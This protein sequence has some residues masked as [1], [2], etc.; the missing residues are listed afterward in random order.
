MSSIASKGPTSFL[1]IGCFLKSWP[2]ACLCVSKN[3]AL[4]VSR[5]S[6]YLVV[7]VCIRSFTSLLKKR[8]KKSIGAVPV[9]LAFSPGVPVKGRPVNKNNMFFLLLLETCIIPACVE[10]L[11]VFVL[12]LDGDVDVSGETLLELPA[13]CLGGA[14]LLATWSGGADLQATR[15]GGG[16]LPASRLG[17]AGLLATWSGGADLQATRS[18]GGELPASRLGGAGITVVSSSLPSGT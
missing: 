18:G 5:W 4:L 1:S 12:P 13:I 14:G 17:G 8:S 10:V 2:R 9:M 16:E 3:A 15:S 11:G 6:A 7:S